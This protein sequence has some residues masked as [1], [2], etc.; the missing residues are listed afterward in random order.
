MP[1]E[2]GTSRSAALTSCGLVLASVALLG[3][4]SREEA[5]DTAYPGASAEAETLFLTEPQVAEAAALADVDLPSPMVGR[6]V[7]R[8]DGQVVGRAYV[9]TH[10]V[11]TKRESLLIALDA[12]GRV[13]RIDVT[14][15]LEP[16]EYR[17]PAAWL[18]QFRDGALSDDLELQRR[19]RPI[20]GASL[21]ARAVTD[22]VRRVLAIDRVLA[23]AA[24]EEPR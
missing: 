14:A 17:A 1:S 12:S 23:S 15:F 13:Q 22:A 3:Q 2:R 19:I 8:R 10:L 7:I 5:L 6:F 4:I 16:A 11:R 20:A 18:D 9:D 21:T 24:Q